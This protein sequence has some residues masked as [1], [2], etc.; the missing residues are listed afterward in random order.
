LRKRPRREFV[1]A[2]DISF[3]IFILFFILFFI[4]FFCGIIIIPNM[5]KTLW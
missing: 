1:W 5:T 4:F 2:E 3:F